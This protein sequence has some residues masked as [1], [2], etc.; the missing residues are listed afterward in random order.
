MHLSGGG[1]VTIL[2]VFP[3]AGESGGAEGGKRKSEGTSPQRA[4][5]VAEEMRSRESRAERL[6]PAGPARPRLGTLNPHGPYR[7]LAGETRGP[8]RLVQRRWQARRVALLG[9]HEP[10]VAVE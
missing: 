4:Q 8:T 10:P 1:L 6:D 9:W 5:R 3:G 7:A 2:G